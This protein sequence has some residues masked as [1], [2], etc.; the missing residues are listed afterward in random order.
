VLGV[1]RSVL[2]LLLLVGVIAAGGTGVTR[3]TGTPLPT[4]ESRVELGVVY[5]TAG[6][7]DLL[8][9]VYHPPER[10][11]PRPAVLVIHGGGL[12]SGSRTRLADLAASLAE[13]GYVTFAIDYRLFTSP[14]SNPWPAQLDD[15]QRAVRWV[16]AHAPRYGVDPERVCAVGHSSGGQLAALLG[17]RETRDNTDPA[18]AAYSSRVGCVI[19]ISGV[20]DVTD[21]AIVACYAALLGGLPEAVPEAYR[22]AS[23]LYHIDE[24]TGPFLIR[25]AADD[26]TVPVEQA[27]RLV[28]ALH[29]AG[30]DVV[31]AESPHGGH[32]LRSNWDRVRPYALVFLELQLHPER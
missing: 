9:D 18:L 3:A 27:R 6:G 26:P 31:Y 7:Q 12:V 16:R 1:L 14:T 5:G 8:L 11:T 23:P 25:H 2:L 13:A 29:D 19:D 28:K 20:A 15:A 21:Q 17:T 30:V 22:D 32:G 4:A 24:E 10:A